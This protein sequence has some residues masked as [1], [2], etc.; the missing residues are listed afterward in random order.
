[1]NA[2]KKTAR[3]VGALFLLAFVT[4]SLGGLLS[5]LWSMSTES[6]NF[7]INV[8]ANSIRM[9]ISILFDLISSAAVV[10]L[11]IMLFASLKEQNKNIALLGLGLFFVEAIMLAVSR[12]SVFSLLQ[13]SA[14]YV[15]AGAPDSFYFH[16]LGILFVGAANWGYLI[17]MFFYGLGGIMFYYLFYKSKLIPRVLSVWGLIAKT[18]LLTA[19]LLIIF[20]HSVGMILMVPTGLFE[21]FIG[22]WLIIKGFNSSAINS[23]FTKT[24]INEIK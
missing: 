18:M 8:S 16:T 10:A 12:I 24:D 19:A 14:E 2:N 11:A 5:G 17:L 3:I 21:I 13:L 7:L 15:K 4:G 20:G 22:I 6:P 9:Q 1:M 23:G